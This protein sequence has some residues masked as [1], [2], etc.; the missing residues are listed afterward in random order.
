MEISDISSLSSYSKSSK[1]AFDDWFFDRD[2]MFEQQ[3]FEDDEYKMLIRDKFDTKRKHSN[4]FGNHTARTISWRPWWDMNHPTIEWNNMIETLNRDVS[5]MYRSI[6]DES[7]DISKTNRFAQQKSYLAKKN[8]WNV[9]DILEANYIKKRT[10]QDNLAVDQKML[11]YSL[12]VVEAVFNREK[13]SVKLN[14]I[15]SH[16]KDRITRWMVIDGV[17]YDTNIIHVSTHGISFTP[18]GVY[19]H[20][21]PPAGSTRLDGRITTVYDLKYN[22]KQELLKSK[23]RSKYTP[24]SHSLPEIEIGMINTYHEEASTDMHKGREKFSAEYRLPPC[25][26]RILHVEVDLGDDVQIDAIST[27]GRAHTIHSRTEHDSDYWSD[28]YVNKVIRFVRE[29]ES[30][31][32]TSFDLLYRKHKSKDW[33]S[34]GSMQGNGD[35]LTEVLTQV[36]L[37]ARYLRFVPLT[38]TRSPSFQIGVFGKSIPKKSVSTV[39]PINTKTIEYEVF[40]PSRK[41]FYTKLQKRKPTWQ[42]ASDEIVR[43]EKTKDL[44]QI[45]RDELNSYYDELNSYDDDSYADD[46]YDGC[47]NELHDVNF[48]DDYD[49]VLDQAEY[50]SDMKLLE[51]HLKDVHGYHTI[52]GSN[53]DIWYHEDKSLYSTEPPDSPKV[54]VLPAPIEEFPKLELSVTESPKPAEPIES[55]KTPPKTPPMTILDGDWQ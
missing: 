38:Y 32:V 30:H 45:V 21:D 22:K 12:P 14:K 3:L 52:F 6:V 27:V 4:I 1:T 53:G 29:K 25:T 28:T 44:R 35:R 51:Q 34:L 55:P 7:L 49:S 54:T 36:D 26:T 23:R 8:T 50:N 47:T 10:K 9:L 40:V 15:L 41:M 43:N 18:Y 46:P 37:V 5:I 48:Q 19:K 16:K 2:E 42:Y 17:K 20:A 39:E 31:F 11:I 24:E 13:P 33:I